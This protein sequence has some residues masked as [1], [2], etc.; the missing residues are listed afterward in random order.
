M[1]E[2]EDIKLR[3][4]LNEMNL[5]SPT[6]NFSIG[7]MNKIFEENSLL[8][9]V[10]SERILGKGFWLIF[11]L[12]VILLAII[13]YISTSGMTIDSQFSNI[14]PGLNSS[15]VSTGY[16]SIFERI[17]TVPISIVGILLASS[18]LLFIDRIIV[19]NSKVFQKS[20]QI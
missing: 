12:F 20:V 17:G 6:S 5:E 18:T 10:K 14:L 13:Y 11:I 4:L 15:R 19:A 7:V 3:A 16:Q 1:N 9:K 2:L 8:E